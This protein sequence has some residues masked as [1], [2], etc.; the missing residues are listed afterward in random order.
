MKILFL[1]SALTS[2]EFAYAGMEKMLVWLANAIS[3]SNHEVIVCTL[4]DKKG[5]D[6]I[7]ANIKTIPLGIHY[8]SSFLIRNLRLFLYVPFVLKRLLS[9]LSVDYV[10]SFGDS[11]FFPSVFLKSRCGYKLIV[12][13]RGD[14]YNS[15]G[16]LENIRQ[17]L[18]RFSDTVVFQTNGARD[19]YR[20]TRNLN[21]KSVVIP[22]PVSIPQQC[23]LENDSKILLSVGR[24]DLRQKR[25]DL[26]LDAFNIIHQKYP[27]W[28][29]I[30]CG[31][32]DGKETIQKLIRDYALSDC[33]TMTGAVSNV[34]EYMRNAEIFLLTSDFEGI[35]NAL[36]EAMALGMPVVSTDCSPGGAALL[37]D[38]NNNG[39][40][41]ERGNV[42]NYAKAIAYLIDNKQEAA[43]MGKEARISM[44][45]YT[46]EL[47]TQKWISIF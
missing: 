47:I 4:Y 31:S 13:E 18:F 26:L 27:D 39:I 42:D 2:G 38:N 16:F 14:P 29:L 19:Y 36:L 35:P 30:I 40:L 5:N 28:K 25:Q 6:R 37:I 11:A 8:S 15:S 22:N 46:P 17:K 1:Y 7:N 45:N 24:L 23:W 3:E 20:N 44:N 41:V 32:G 34:L 12:S 9:K 21:V 10:V 43:K 33:V